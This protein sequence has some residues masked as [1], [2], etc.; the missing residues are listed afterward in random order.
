M[1]H[2]D[3]CPLFLRTTGEAEIILGEMATRGNSGSINRKPYVFA[4]HEFLRGI[5]TKAI[6][7]IGE[8]CEAT[9]RAVEPLGRSSRH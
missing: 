1:M 7:K 2:R 4:G 9:I 6:N 8:F 5:D 3:T